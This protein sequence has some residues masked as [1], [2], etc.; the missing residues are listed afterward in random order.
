MK[1][2]QNITIALL[3]TLNIACQNKKSMPEI[4]E[5]IPEL[6]EEMCNAPQGYPIEVYEGGLEK[7]DS[8]GNITNYKGL[9]GKLSSGELGWGSDGGG[10][11]GGNFV[12]THLS[13][14]WLSYAENVF[15]NIDCAIDHDKI[16]K[17]FQ[18]GYPNL[19]WFRNDGRRVKSYYNSIITGF[20]PGGVVV[21][22]L[23]GAGKQVEIGRYKGSKH[24]VDPEEIA[25]LEQEVHVLFEKDFRDAVMSDPAVVP[26]KVQKANQG[27]PIPYGLW[28]TYRNRYSWR[29]I[30]ELQDN[31]VFDFAHATMINGEIEQL[32]DITLKENKFKKR[33]LPKLINIYWKDKD[34]QGYGANDIEF[35]EK[36]VKEAF[37]VIYK[38]NKELEAELVFTVNQA[39][40][41]VT[42]MLVHDN[43]KIRLPK[44]KVE[45][46]KLSK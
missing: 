12:P 45:V 42:V 35:D 31:G 4:E 7:R 38:D 34:N 28:D 39:N 1:T 8:Q 15:Y 23:S 5:N 25:G 3:L 17:L 29:P 19:S 44:T 20:A 22:W 26:L 36:E 33:G 24:I 30:F 21:I 27:K 43:V 40:N 2:I 14:T 6:W 16:L 9:N 41:F 11:G 10:T 46:F 37:D 13:C 32:F 18:E